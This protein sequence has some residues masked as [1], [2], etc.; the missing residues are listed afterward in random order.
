MA[1]QERPWKAYVSENVDSHCEDNRRNLPANGLHRDI[2]QYPTGLPGTFELGGRT[3]HER[4]TQLDRPSGGP[5]TF[6]DHVCVANGRKGSREDRLNRACGTRERRPGVE[7]GIRNEG[8]NMQRKSNRIAW[9]VGPSCLAWVV[10]AW[11]GTAYAGRGPE[12]TTASRDQLWRQTLDLAT[13]GE[14]DAAT[15]AIRQIQSATPVTDQVKTWLEDYEAKQAA[16]RELDRADFDKYVDYAKARIERKEYSEALSW[17]LAALDCAADRDA[18]LESKWVVQLANDALAKAEEHQK[19]A[20]AEALAEKVATGRDPK[21]DTPVEH[22]DVAQTEAKDKG[23]KPTEDA[24]TEKAEPTSDDDADAD[25][26]AEENLDTGWRKAWRIYSQ[27]ALLFE[28]EPRYEKLE[29]EAVT[30][31]RLDAMFNEK[32]HWEEQVDKVRWADAEQALQFISMYYVEPANFRNVAEAG[33]EQLLLLADSKTAQKTFKG[34]GNEDDRAD[35]VARVKQRLA[36]IRSAPSLDAA[37]CVRHFRRVVKDINPETVRIPEE[38]V[39]EELMRGALEPLDDFT[40]IIWPTDSDDFDKHTR[41]DFVGVGISIIKNRDEQI[42]VVTPLDDTPAYR[43]GVQ[44]GDLITHVDGKSLKGFSTNKVVDTITGREGTLVNLTIVRE[45]KELAFPLTRAKVKIQSVKGLDRDANDPEQWNH[46]LD[47]ENGIGYIRVTNFQKNTVEDLTNVLSELSAENL[48]GLVLD[49]RGN[50]GGLLD[51]AYNMS[52]LFLSRG[53][54]V[55]STKG[56]IRSEDQVF[57]TPGNGP[58]NQMPLAVLVDGR[59]ASASE[60]VSGAIRDN[61]RGVIVGERTFGK[62]SVQNLIP[63]SRAGAKLKITTARYYLPSGVSLHRT[64]GAE[65]WGVSPHVPVKLVQKER[66]NVWKQQREASLL[67]PAKKED[68]SE[69]EKKKDET[70]ADGEEK[71]K[72]E[73]DAVADGKPTKEGELPPLEQPDENDRPVAD[74]QLDAALL[75]MRMTVADKTAPTLAQAP[76]AEETRKP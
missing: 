27:L 66:I 72:A 2:R 9:G 52:S 71:L 33:L 76:A 39:V 34:L 42:E 58:F 40:N 12:T 3:S 74:P 21:A 73:T 11:V 61:H 63:L 28:R 44:A 32:N 17:A 23:D 20:E 10:L 69:D 5:Y 62:F 59:S 75:L 19:E 41:G 53:D 50:P 31:I 65:V 43:A 68:K 7:T 26:D 47:K 67:G 1:G 48:R 13:R 57:P 45:G 30:H 16:R 54:T 56:R 24:L 8:V 38:L 37:D 64:P 55:V 4:V 14:F 22:A 18:F 29:R 35:F 46:W 51:S 60:I 15:N 6:A 36:Q 70:V 49:L 25:A